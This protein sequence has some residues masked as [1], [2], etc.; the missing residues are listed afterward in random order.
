MPAKKQAA[1]A[2]LENAAKIFPSTTS[3]R[4][5]K[6][7]RFYCELNEAVDPECLQAA[8]DTT[9]LKFPFYRSILK[10]GLFW[11]YFEDSRIAAFAHPETRPPC[12]QLYS[13]NR[14]SL[15]FDVSYY[16]NRINV[17]VY[18]ALTDGTGA[19]HFLKALV[20][21][22]LTRRHGDELSAPVAIDYDAS[23][24]QK[25]DDSFSKYYSKLHLPKQKKAA[26][27]Y[28]I[29]DEK[30][31][32]GSLGI[33]EGRMSV[34]KLL[35]LSHR[36]SSTITTFLTAVLIRSIGDGL[37]LRERNKPV[38]ITVPVNLR[39]FF[40]SESARNFFGIID[41]GY[42]FSKQSGEL[43][44][45]CDHVSHMLK[46][47]LTEQ[48]LSE[49]I[50]RFASYER[51]VVARIVPIMLKNIFLRIANHLVERGITAAF[52]NVGAVKMPPEISGYIRQFGVV[53]STNRIQACMCSFGDNFIIS[54]SSPFIST[55]IQRRFFRTLTEMGVDVEI[56][57]NIGGDADAEV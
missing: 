1:W 17:E 33:I 18:H 13:E 27:A 23:E 11:Y 25:K 2:R 42:N 20:T 26:V 31:P 39:K 45:I 15:L 51:A 16:G 53:C 52:S 7:F 56:T 48:K 22:Y 21:A 54:F 35:E 50:N 30:L 32:V 34:G 36:H 6:V 38:V 44:D 8:L 28:R 9:I 41:I 49:R 29:R 4:D 12:S 24:A 3:R 37:A 43:Q 55:D 46:E 19:M 57:S 40:A 14:K 5:T 10:K 47:E